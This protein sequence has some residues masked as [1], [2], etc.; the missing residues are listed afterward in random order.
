MP[1]GPALETRLRDAVAQLPDWLQAHIQRVEAGAAHLARLHGLDEQRARLA[2]LAH[3]LARHRK[4]QELLS[5][6]QQYSI[7][8]DEVELAAPILVHGPVAARMLALDFACDDA[9][10]MAGV[11]CHTTARAG[12]SA[13]E[14]ALF[15]A[16]KVEPQKLRRD[17]ALQAVLA[18]SEHDLDTAVLL[19]L[20]YLIERTLRDGLLLHP[21]T[22]EARNDLLTRMPPLQSAI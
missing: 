17:G 9:E 2:A 13:L 4:P 22:L 18:A 20:D 7:E 19:Y 3:D 15:V 8:P 1:S 10:I 21:R 6:A 5:L 14:K 11:D 16:D 12:M